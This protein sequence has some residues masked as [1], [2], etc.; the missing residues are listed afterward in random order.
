MYNFMIKTNLIG[1][2]Q[3]LLI[4]V[5]SNIM[6]TRIFYTCNMI[7]VIIIN[8]DAVLWSIVLLTLCAAFR[9]DL[10]CSEKNE[11]I[12][13]FH[14]CTYSASYAFSSYLN[15]TWNSCTVFQIDRWLQ[16]NK[17]IDM[18]FSCVIFVLDLALRLWVFI[19]LQQHIP[20]NIFFI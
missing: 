4:I 19:H 6:C 7:K 16:I 8:L 13:F 9:G 17:C 15:V 5:L 14:V 20:I 2:I 12:N 1:I 3:A 10:V 11:L 18:I